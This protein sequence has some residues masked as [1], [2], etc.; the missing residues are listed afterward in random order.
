MTGSTARLPAA[1]PARSRAA[2]AKPLPCRRRRPARS[3]PGCRLSG[4]GFGGGLPE[5]FAAGP[6][7]LPTLEISLRHGDLAYARHPVLVGHY[8]GTP[9]SAPKPC[10]TA[11]SATP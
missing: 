1:P 2:E 9:W 10:S 8:L 6:P 11:N 5:G 3:Y 4:F 7:A